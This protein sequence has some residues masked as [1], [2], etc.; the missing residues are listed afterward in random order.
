VN[1][2]DTLIDI[3]VKRERLLA[4]CNAQRDDLAVLAEQ[5]QGPLQ[6][7]DRVVAGAQYLR[8][9]PLVLGAAVAL[10]AVIERRHL[11]KWGQRAFFAWR[12][13][14]LLKESLIKSAD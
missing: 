12:T 2:G 10:A 13:Y 4:R 7:A 8:R 5:W 3:M 9:H 11:W 1:R 6:V 14:G